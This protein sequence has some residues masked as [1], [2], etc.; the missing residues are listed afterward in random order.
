M[1][2]LRKIAHRIAAD[3]VR[4]AGTIEFKKDSGPLRRDIRIQG[5]QWS[6]DVYR[7]L[8]K[9]LWAA[10]RSH[11]YGMAALRLF[12]K[13]PSS[14]FSPDGLLGGVGYIQSIKDM[15]SGMSKSVEFLSS[16]TDTM[17]DEINASHW[18]NAGGDPDA[19]WL[20]DQAQQV[21]ANPED[22]VQQEFQESAPAEEE[23]FSEVVNPE[24]KNPGVLTEEGSGQEGVT[25]EEEDSSDEDWGYHQSAEGPKPAKRPEPRKRLES[26]LPA[27][28]SEQSEG[29]NSD[30]EQVM[31]TVVPEHGSYSS[32]IIKSVEKILNRTAASALPVEVMSEPRL[33]H[34]GPGESP[35]EMGS[36]SDQ[37]E[38]PSDDPIWEGFSQLDRIEESGYQDGV[39][40]EYPPNQGYTYQSWSE[41]ASRVAEVPPTYS[42][43]PGANNDKNLNYY[44]LGLTEDDVNWMR[45]NSAPNP[46]QSTPQ[47]KNR[48]VIDPLWDI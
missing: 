15:R 42:W 6:P 31:R 24:A 11:S 45:A 25:E 36:Y 17:Y 20:V 33:L 23:E 41:I 30:S 29:V 16:F 21:K 26:Q 43:L 10:E 4:T 39:T 38:R 1:V 13:L 47:K 12:S 14:E 5:F 7:S 44:E 48:P 40:G 27:D 35:E 46:P 3:Q 37:G 28:D 18:A 22:Y 8:T 2:D 34:R 19:Q 9:I 32:V